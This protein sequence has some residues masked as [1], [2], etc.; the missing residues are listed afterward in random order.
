M[1]A[2]DAF[3]AIQVNGTKVLLV[4]QMTIA[5]THPVSANGL[6][7]IFNAFPTSISADFERK[8]ILFV[9]PFSGEL[10]EWQPLWTTKGAVFRNENI[11]TAA[12]N[13]EQWLY[14]YELVIP[15]DEK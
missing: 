6:V 12:Q 1:E 13:F 14:R 7:N 3:C 11:P 8:V 10:S 9:T 4:L 2:G 15:D 5:E